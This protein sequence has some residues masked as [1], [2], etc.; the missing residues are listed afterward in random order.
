M[1]N[2]S[3]LPNCLWYL[4]GDYLFIYVCSSNIRQG[5]ELTISYC[6][7]WISSLTERSSQLKQFGIHSCRCLLCLYDGSN[8]PQYEIELKKFFNLRALA[9]Q[10]NLS[11]EKRFDYVEKLK[12]IYEFLT[13]KF[14]QRPIGFLTEFVDLEYISHYFQHENNQHHIQ[15][16][17][18]ERQL[19]F[20]QRLSRVC[21]FTIKDLPK[22]FNPMVLFGTHMQVSLHLKLNYFVI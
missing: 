4:I 3:C 5:D 20:L 21:R 10:K 19:S 15:Q 7:L 1:F 2:H 6:P 18:E 22:I 8:M 14:R 16:F 17:L 9:R 11:C 13:K 12:R